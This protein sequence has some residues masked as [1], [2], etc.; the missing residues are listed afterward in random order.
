MS[1]AR[2]FKIWNNSREIKKGTVASTLSDLKTKGRQ[3]LGIS[4]DDPVLVVLEEDGTEVD[5]EDYFAFLPHNT[6]IMILRQGQ[7]W[8]PQGAGSKGLDE[9]DYMCTD[10][11]EISERTKEL[12]QGL[13][14]N[15]AR[16]ITLSNEDLQT[17]VDMR[18]DALSHLLHDTET[19]ARAVQEACQRHLDDR[20]QT[21]QAMDLLQLYHS[22]RQYSPYVEEG[23]GAKRTKHSN[24]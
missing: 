21:S 22:A 3:L 4:E 13:H 17:V 16:I 23:D 24:T 12:I 19:Y 15:V 6:T 5:D 8:M 18:T 9:P 10:G 2:P 7:T 20:N 11:T 1:V 14:N